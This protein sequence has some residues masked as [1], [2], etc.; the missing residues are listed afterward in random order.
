MKLTVEISLYP[1][2]EEYIPAI[3]AIIERF[4]N[5]PELRAQVTATCTQL[6]GDY[7]RLMAILAIEIKH[8]YETYGRSVFV[9]KFIPDYEP[10]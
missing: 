6:V 5:Y 1:F 2:A 3:K 8:S 4:E 7:D 9:T 10:F